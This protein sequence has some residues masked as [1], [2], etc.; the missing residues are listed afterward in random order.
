MLMLSHGLVASGLFFSVGF[1]YDRYKTRDI[2]CYGSLASLMPFFSVFFFLL[3][4][5]NMAVPLTITFVF[6]ISFLGSLADKL[7]AFLLI[8][9]LPFVANLV[10]SLWLGMR[11]LFGRFNDNVVILNIKDLSHYE[12]IIL[13][14]LVFLIFLLGFFPHIILQS[15]HIWTDYYAF[16]LIERVCSLSV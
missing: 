8:F 4:F 3:L 16:Y 15:L 11:L 13:I 1:L 9:L 5:S 12:F 10:F 7:G 14:T 2:Q 6:E